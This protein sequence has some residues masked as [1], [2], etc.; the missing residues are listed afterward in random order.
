MKSSTPQGPPK[1][2]CG[3]AQHLEAL[4]DII[5]EELVEQFLAEANAE[6]IGGVEEGRNDG[7]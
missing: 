1:H 3:T 4:L 7:R 6:G 5:A 2:A